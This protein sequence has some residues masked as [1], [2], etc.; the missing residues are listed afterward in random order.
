MTE[1]DRGFG[2]CFTEYYFI[3]Q[4]CKIELKTKP[5]Q[6]QKSQNNKQKKTHKILAI[7][8]LLPVKIIVLEKSESSNVW[9]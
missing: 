7:N 2:P 4:Y 5:K 3:S 6:Q 1:K 8:Q 9:D